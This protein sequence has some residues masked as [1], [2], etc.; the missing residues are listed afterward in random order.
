MPERGYIS[1]SNCHYPHLAR[2]PDGAVLIKNVASNSA[3]DL[4]SFHGQRARPCSMTAQQRVFLSLSFIGPNPSRTTYR[5]R[6]MITGAG[7]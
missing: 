7:R 1:H 3:D 6:N 4:I 2:V 5:P